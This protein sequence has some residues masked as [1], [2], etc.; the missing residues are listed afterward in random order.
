MKTMSLTCMLL[1]PA[2]F[3]AAM[4]AYG[5]E[6]VPEPLAGLRAANASDRQKAFDSIVTERENMI[7]DLVGMLGEKDINKDFNGPF[8][9]AILLLGE[10]R[11]TKAV[12][13]LSDLL[14]YQPSGEMIIEEDVPSE[15]LYPAAVALSKIGYPAVNSMEMAI[16]NAPSKT[17]RDLAAWVILQIEGREQSVKRMQGLSATHQHGRKQF[18]EAEEYIQK[19]GTTASK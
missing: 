11:A 14:L 16:K 6:R 9:R 5:Q 10:L 17:Q 2:V 13:V 4:Y 12:N 18:Q 15:A 19:Y 7:R 1:I 8:H 3:L